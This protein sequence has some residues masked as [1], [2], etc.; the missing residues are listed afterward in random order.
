MAEKLSE[1][2]MQMNIVDFEDKVISNNLTAEAAFCNRVGDMSITYVHFF[3]FSKKNLMKIL[4]KNLPS[5]LKKHI[6]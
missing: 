1:Q 4:I 2:F 3:S 6:F 5:A